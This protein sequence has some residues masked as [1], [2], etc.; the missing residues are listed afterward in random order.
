MSWIGSNGG[1]RIECVMTGSEDTDEGECSEDD[2]EVMDVGAWMSACIAGGLLEGTTPC[3]AGL[4][5]DCGC[6]CGDWFCGD[7]RD[8]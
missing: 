5:V 6:W 4:G 8:D 1:D 2:G 7:G 3:I